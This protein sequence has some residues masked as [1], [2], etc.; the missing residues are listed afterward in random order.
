MLAGAGGPAA[1]AVDEGETSSTQSPDDLATVE[2]L[3]GVLVE[4]V[5]AKSTALKGLTAKSEGGATLTVQPDASVLASGVNLDQDV[6]VGEEI[7][8]HEHGCPV[9][10][11]TK[12][13]TAA[14]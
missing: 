13:R 11:Q 2:A 5:E 10:A 6:Y 3:A 9:A 12:G 14:A 4:K 1:E 8:A 7:E